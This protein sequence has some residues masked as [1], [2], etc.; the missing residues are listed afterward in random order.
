MHNHFPSRPLVVIYLVYVYI[1]F[2]IY[3]SFTILGIGFSD[4]LERVAFNVPL[5]R[6]M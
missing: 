2:N 6:Y 3:V 5:Y 4:I 1:H